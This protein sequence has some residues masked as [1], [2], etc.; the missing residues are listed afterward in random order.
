MRLSD[1]ILH[2]VV[3]RPLIDLERNNGNTVVH[4][5]VDLIENLLGLD[6]AVGQDHDHKIRVLDRA[7]DRSCIIHTGSRIPIIDPTFDIVLLQNANDHIGI[8]LVLVRVRYHNAFH[9]CAPFRS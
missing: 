1:V 5:R 4:R 6:A 3:Q 9:I 7:D 2:V 8:L